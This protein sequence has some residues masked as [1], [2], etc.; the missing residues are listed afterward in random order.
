MKFKPGDLVILN[1]VWV[2]QG[3]A[4]A[5][6]YE[7]DA[8]IILKPHGGLPDVWEVLHGSSGQT[9]VFHQDYF[10]KVETQ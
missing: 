6:E 4:H 3:T 2:R 10:D 9:S 1:A 7:G 5:S 8:C